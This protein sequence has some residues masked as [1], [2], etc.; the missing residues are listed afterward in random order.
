MTAIVRKCPLC[1]PSS[2]SSLF[3]SDTVRDYYRCKHCSLIFVP[4]EYF[5]SSEEEKAEYDHHQNSP[6]DAGYRTFLSKLFTPML[7]RIPPNSLGLDF[8]SGPGPTL[9]VMFE[10]QGHSVTLYDP[11]YAPNRNV[12]RVEYDFVCASEV[13][14]HFQNPEVD[15]ELIWSL[16]KPRGWLGVMTGIAQDREAFAGWRYKDDRSHIVFFS[17]E[18]MEWI[19]RKWQVDMFCVERGVFLFQKP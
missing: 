16:V 2:G 7:E 5:L 9:S 19:A 13:V 12:L 15:L 8:G 1:V 10:E 3:H 18:T 6:D 4:P 11:F 14:E 17:V